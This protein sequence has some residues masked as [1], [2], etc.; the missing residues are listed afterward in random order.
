MPKSMDYLQEIVVQFPLDA[1]FM[2]ALAFPD[3]GPR[4]GC[5]REE[6]WRV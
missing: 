5:Q 6:R 4:L 2:Q 1:G 3:P